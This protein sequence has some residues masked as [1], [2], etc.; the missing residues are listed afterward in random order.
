MTGIPNFL[1]SL[2]LGLVPILLMLAFAKE[3]Q[4]F[5]ICLIIALLTDALDGLI[6]RRSHATS[7]TGAKLDS[8][9]DL[10][11]C[12][13]IP[14]CTWWL[15]P[16]VVRSELTVIV[17][18][19]LFYAAAPCA[20]LL[21]FRRL[22]SYHTWAAK[23]VATLAAIAFVTIFAGGPGRVLHWLGP[24]VVLACSEEILIT[25]VLRQWRADVPSLWHAW[26]L[27]QEQR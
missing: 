27:R 1:S 26:Q 4:V 16:E 24:F 7:I 21:K 3:H 20:G 11:I 12:L 18:A 6:A 2:R 8:T 22:P 19:L 25:F 13:A 9:A 23:I 5:L 15:R 17:T 14:P 10:A